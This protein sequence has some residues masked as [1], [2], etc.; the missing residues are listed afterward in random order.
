MSTVAA[1]P[2][3]IASPELPAR[4]PAAALDKLMYLA[5]LLHDGQCRCVITLDRR[6][7]GPR[8]ARAVELSLD[9]EPVLGCK[10]VLHPWQH[11]WERC[12]PQDAA[13]AFSQVRAQD[14]EPEIHAF[15]AEPMDALRGPQVAVRLIRSGQDVLCIKLDHMVADATGSLDYI[16]LLGRLY[17]RLRTDPD[18]VP[19]VLSTADRGQGQVLRG[20]GLSTVLQGCSRFRY[21]RSDWGF[22]RTSRDLSGRAFSERRIGSEQ[23]ARLKVY[24]RA[25]GVKFTDV[26]VTAFYRA[27]IHILNPP[28]GARLPVQLT[29]DLRRYLPSG[30][31]NAVCDLAGVYYPSIRHNPAAGFDRTLADVHA[32]TARA[33]AGHSWLSQ[34][35]FLELM[36]LVP[37]GLQTGLAQM[38]MRRESSSGHAHPF[39][40]NLGVIDP[41]IFDFG[42]AAAADVSLFGPTAFPPN[43]LVTVY[44]FRGN[45]SVASSSCPTAADPLLVDA[46]FTRFLAELPA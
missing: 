7:D 26:L 1:P 35:L 34:A 5:R 32:A 14:P 41:G 19:P 31:A 46:F 29:I 16:R 25:R 6:L 9:A 13:N 36:N 40:S 12:L 27:L 43:F 18:Y 39:F 33:R 4:I 15:L 45:L 28:A 17:D 2:I 21:P 30:R 23:V 20:A 42:D 38:V 10:Y 37:A 44:K 11:R 3:R 24:C 22:P 8:M